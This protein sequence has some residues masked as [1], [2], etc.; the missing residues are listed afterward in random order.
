MDK[1]KFDLKYL[2]I[3]EGAKDWYKALGNGWRLALIGIVL[4]LIIAG[5]IT[6]KNFLFPKPSQNVNKP[7]A[8]ALPFSKVDKIDQTSTQ[9]LM[10]EKSWEAGVG[11]GVITYDNKAGMA[12]GGWVK[13]KW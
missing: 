11:G 9:I 10:E 2:L 12:V 13:K 4:I 8:V 7:T 1:S 3:G 6:I 5:G